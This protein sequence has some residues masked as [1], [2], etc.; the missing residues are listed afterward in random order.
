MSSP[1][2][3]KPFPQPE[4]GST[5]PFWRTELDPLDNHQSTP[6]PTETDILIIGGG[7]VGASAAYRLLVENKQDPP[8]RVTLLE[9]RGLCSGATGRNGK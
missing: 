7:Y 9:A 2:V 6:F 3:G 4:Q 8:P 5:V 1:R